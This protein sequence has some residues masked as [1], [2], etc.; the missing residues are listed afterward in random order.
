MARKEE[1][2]NL[3]EYEIENYIIASVIRQTGLSL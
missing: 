3:E 1:N 2:K